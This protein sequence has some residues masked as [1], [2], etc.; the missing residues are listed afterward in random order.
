MSILRVKETVNVK[1][2][3]SDARVT[4]VKND[5]YDHKDPLVKEYRWAFAADVEQATAEP[6]GR[7]A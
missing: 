3:N 7:R 1:D 6:G 4:L 5:P 2:P